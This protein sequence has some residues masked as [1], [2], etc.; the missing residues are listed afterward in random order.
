ME[1]K[2]FVEALVDGDLL[3]D[4]FLVKSVRRAETRA[5]K[6][7]LLLTLADRSGEISGPAWDNAEALEPICVTGAVVRVRG[8]AQTYNN[9]LQVQIRDV[10]A[11]DDTAWQPETFVATSARSQDD[12]RTELDRL[13]TS[14]RTP[15]LRAL[16]RHIFDGG[17]TGPLFQ[18]APAAKGI[19]HAYL[20]GLLEHSLSM[21]RVAALLADH[22]RGIDR[23]L[24]VTGAL[25]HDIGKTEELLNVTGVIEYTDV[26]RLK[27]HLVIGCEMIGRAARGIDGFPD[28][29]LTHLQHLVLSHHGRLEFGSPVLPMTAEALLLSFIDDLDAKMN[30]VE[31]L[32]RKVKTD[33]P[34]WSDYQRS[35]ERF[36]LLRPLSGDSEKAAIGEEQD[37]PVKQ[38]TLF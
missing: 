9:K 21:A 33:M 6:P 22:Y 10:Q 3:D 24:L 1:K 37:I 16:L 35:L 7:Y 34:Q 27:G 11:V 38:R 31:Q 25:L 14:V 32:S 4:L 15:Y 30:L 12:M 19:H 29:V 8:Q 23:D 20:G 17:A 26:G 36:L 18:T 2:Q 5:G 13:I 28:E